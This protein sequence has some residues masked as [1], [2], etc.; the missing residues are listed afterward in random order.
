MRPCLAL[1]LALVA[2]GDSDGVG[3]TGST[4]AGANG[5]SGG[6]T[7]GGSGGG[8]T[9]GGGAATGGGGAATG[10]GETGGGGGCSP[11]TDD[12]SAIGVACGNGQGCPAGYTCQGYSGVVFQE[13]CA[14]L[15]AEDCDCPAATS[16][17][18][19]SDKTGTWMECMFLPD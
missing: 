7:T 17:E 5:A 11:I 1:V 13:A 8:A 15:C 10:G 19:Q 6:G 14:I 3:G 9:G 16:C 2:C 18:M 4:G 12:T